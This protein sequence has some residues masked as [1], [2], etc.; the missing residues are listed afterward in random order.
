MCCACNTG[1]AHADE[2]ELM[3]REGCFPRGLQVCFF[4]CVIQV[5]STGVLCVC[6]TTRPDSSLRYRRYIN[7]LLTYYR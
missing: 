5:R 7:H 4:V 3:L 6:N 2:V 1:E